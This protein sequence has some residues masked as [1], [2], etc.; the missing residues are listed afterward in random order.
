MMLTFK[1]IIKSTFCELLRDLQLSLDL[2]NS[3][4]Q[5]KKILHAWIGIG[6]HGH[7]CNSC[8][9]INMTI[10]YDPNQSKRLSSCPHIIIIWFLLYFSIWFIR[11][12]IWFTLY[13]FT[14][15]LLFLCLSKSQ[16]YNNLDMTNFFE[17]NCINKKKI[18][19]MSDD[20]NQ[21]TKS[22]PVIFISQ[23][24][25]IIICGCFVLDFSWAIGASNA[26]FILF[27]QQ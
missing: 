7:S 18:L 27:L 13:S 1:L 25:N 2:Y 3:L 17:R 19:K 11:S 14:Q 22:K 5:L 23:L 4:L 16:V 21:N 26:N 8:C 6:S 9:I 20:D 12:I 15:L 10:V 24:I